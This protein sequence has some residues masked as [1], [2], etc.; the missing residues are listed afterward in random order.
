M[1][2]AGV[3]AALLPSAATY[4]RK[5]KRETIWV[6]NPAWE[7]AWYEALD[8][9][10][11]LRKYRGEWAIY[12]IRAELSLTKWDPEKQKNEPPGSVLI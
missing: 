2:K 8:P 3:G 10:F 5:W 12:D 4:A 6:V 9:K 7:N 11:D 1:L